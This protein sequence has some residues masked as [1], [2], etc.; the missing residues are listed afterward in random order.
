MTRRLG[1]PPDPSPPSAPND[2]RPRSGGGSS[3]KLYAFAR[4]RDSRCA[5]MSGPS[6]WDQYWHADRL[7]SCLNL[8]TPNYTADMRA[9]WSGFLS[10]LPDGARVL[11]ICTGNGAVAAI[12]VET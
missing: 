4:F 3:S 6:I 2:R 5:F 12:A 10:P 11:D 8:D 9:G 1:P 7:A